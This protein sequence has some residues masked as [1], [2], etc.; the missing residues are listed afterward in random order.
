MVTSA[1]QQ[2]ELVVKRK[3]SSSRRR[4]AT[5]LNRTPKRARTISPIYNPRFQVVYQQMPLN[6]PQKANPVLYLE[7]LIV[8]S[9]KVG[10][11]PF[12]LFNRNLLKTN[13]NIDA[14]GKITMAIFILVWSQILKFKKQNSRHNDI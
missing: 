9:L 14:D 13:E 7:W 11:K 6:E 4:Y 3:K 2:R 10:I 12:K 8:C 5:P 1:A